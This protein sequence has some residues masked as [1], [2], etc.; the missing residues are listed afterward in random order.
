[1]RM[2]A[3]LLLVAASPA[4]PRAADRVDPR[5]PAGLPSVITRD[6]TQF[7]MPS[8]IAGRTYRIQVYRPSMPPPPQGYPVIVFT[9]GN[10]TF[11][12]AA[13]QMN[14]RFLV[15]LKP[16]I[17][18]GIGYPSANLWDAVRMRNRDLIP[19][20]P[21][22]AF[23]PVF[24]QWGRF[25]GYTAADTGGAELFFRF[26]T[27]EL[28]PRLA[29]TARIDPKQQALY[30]HSL[31]GLFTLYT[32]F[33]HPTAFSTYIVSSPSILVNERQIRA[34]I[35]RFRSEIEAQ[36]I[37]PRVLF[38]SG[39]YE[40]MAPTALAALPA[41]ERLAW[42]TLGVSGLANTVELADDLA[43]MRG[44]PGYEVR[45][46]VFA[47]ENHNSVVPASVARALTFAFSVAPTRMRY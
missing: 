47:G 11:N 15:D 20:K 18:V 14:S 35:P 44:A 2:L 13:D 12:T 33:E 36:R 39:E 16:A 40:S 32:L 43:D 41:A 1:M 31:G 17:V 6:V 3:L 10:L 8:R 38:L 9:D 27:E 26:I 46:H 28:R 7:D 5:V 22:G 29:A 23:A 42:T 34:G 19:W 4:A 37:A 21:S 45:K 25:G 30:G 24:A